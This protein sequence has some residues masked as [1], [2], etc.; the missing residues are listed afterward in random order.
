MS[1]WTIQSF[2]Q[3]KLSEYCEDHIRH[4]Q[5]RIHNEKREYI[6][7][8]NEVDY[9]AHIENIYSIVPLIIDFDKV[10]VQ[11]EERLI[12]AEKFSRFF[13]VEAG[14]SYKKMVI[15]FHV[16]F[17]GDRELLA[18]TPSIRSLWSETIAIGAED[19]V[20]EIINFDNDTNSI[21][22]HFDEFKIH[23]EDQLSYVTSEI[24]KYNANVKFR[25]TEIF[26]RRKKE[27]L[28]QEGLLSSLGFPLKGND[29]VSHTFSVPSPQM[30]EQIKIQKPNASSEKFIPEPT[31]EKSDYFKILGLI[32]D[33]GK[34]FERLPS[35]YA[36]KK[37]EHLRD[38]FIM[39][40]EPQFEGSATGE[41]FNKKG[42]TDIL[43]RHDGSNVF[44]AECKF[45]KGAKG[46]LDTITQLLGYLT[47]RDSKAA[48][49][50]FVSNK[51]FSAAIDAV[52]RSTPKHLNYVDFDK[53]MDE[54]WFNYNFHINGD[55]NRLVKLAV[56]LY[57]IPK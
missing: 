6:L 20:Y 3:G 57:H 7:N 56:M 21:K 55:R 49:I 24:S 29:D 36:G 43:L 41:T 42:K 39:M 2:G 45:W 9:I 10:S 52:K 51:D 5:E 47:W 46:F 30:R 18:R 26:N 38:H 44:I 53:E 12:P 27:I 25:A 31:L 48:V 40:L 35:V 1:Y 23:M 11:Q 8:V 4:M 17:S 34:E 14:K 32:H 16:P 13:Y 19:F 50:M 22:G 15:C 33:V 28:D 37:E 54:T